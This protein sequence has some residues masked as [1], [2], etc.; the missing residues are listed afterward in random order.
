[1]HFN[2]WKDTHQQK[3]SLSG[4]ISSDFCPLIFAFWCTQGLNLF[5]LFFSQ[6]LLYQSYLNHILKYNYGG[7]RPQDHSMKQKHREEQFFLTESESTLKAKHE[8]YG[9][10]NTCFYNHDLQVTVAN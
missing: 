8:Q 1:M 2:K 6:S 5:K 3:L 9:M 7:Q 4:T 10:Q